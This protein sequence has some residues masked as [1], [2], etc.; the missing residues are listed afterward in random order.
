V[1]SIVCPA[2]RC[3]VDTF[4]DVSLAR[5]DIL[6]DIRTVA[7]ATCIDHLGGDTFLEEAGTFEFANRATPAQSPVVLHN[8]FTVE[9]SALPAGIMALL[10]IGGIRCL[11]LSLDTIAD[12]LGCNWESAK[13]QRGRPGPLDCFRACWRFLLGSREVVAAPPLPR[14]GDVELTVASRPGTPP[15]LR[16]ASPSMPP[17]PFPAP[18]VPAPSFIEVMREL[19]ARTKEEGMAASFVDK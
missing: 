18:L 7:E 3:L 13:R 8:V 4:S 12:S 9:A 10:G 15:A 14:R 2:G 19:K 1:L 5:R 11:D 17:S 16:V 6:T